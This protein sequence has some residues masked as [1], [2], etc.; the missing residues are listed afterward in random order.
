MC[1]FPFPPHERL[2]LH[3]VTAT[4]D[5]VFVQ[6]R[7]VGGGHE[8]KR[9]RTEDR[10]QRTEDRGQRTEDRGQRTEDRGQRTA[11]WSVRTELLCIVLYVVRSSCTVFLMHTCLPTHLLPTS[12]RK[13]LH[14]I[15]C[16][17]VCLWLA[18][19]CMCVFVE[20]VLSFFVGCATGAED[21]IRLGDW[22]TY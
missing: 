1:V 16:L 6:G 9:Q 11:K 8:G 19:L 2:P 14:E 21:F 20:C 3:T 4:R 5:K 13:K 10:G 7:R 17:S 18:G 12:R 15:V 22:L